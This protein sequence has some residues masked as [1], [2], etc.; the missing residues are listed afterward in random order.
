MNLKSKAKIF[1]LEIQGKKIKR[2]EFA[3]E[4]FNG[5]NLAG[6]NEVANSFDGIDCTLIPT[7]WPFRPASRSMMERGRERQKKF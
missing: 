2:K 1:E 6:T 5:K 3:Q 7:G 4:G